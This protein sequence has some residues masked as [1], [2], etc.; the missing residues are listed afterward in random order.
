MAELDLKKSLKKRG[1]PLIFLSASVRLCGPDAPAMGD[2]GAAHTGLADN[3]RRIK[4]C[5]IPKNPSL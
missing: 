4:A 2:G 1:H 3:P 5:F